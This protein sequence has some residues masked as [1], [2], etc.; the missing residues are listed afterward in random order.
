[1]IN[2]TNLY[3]DDCYYENE[4]VYDEEENYF[5]D[6]PELSNDELDYKS[7]NY[8]GKYVQNTIKSTKPIYP[9]NFKNLKNI[10]CL[11][12]LKNT[13]NKSFVKKIVENKKRTCEWVKKEINNKINIFLDSEYPIL[14]AGN[15]KIKIEECKKETESWF[16]VKEKKKKNVKLEEINIIIDNDKKDIITKCHFDNQCRNIKRLN[17]GIYIN[18]NID[19]K[20][21]YLHSYETIENYNNRMNTDNTNT[22]NIDVKEVLKN[23]NIVIPILKVFSKI[24]NP[25]SIETAKKTLLKEVEVEEEV[26]VIKE[27]QKIIFIKAPKSLETH[28]LN[29]SKSNGYNIKISLY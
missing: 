28:I 17:D 21:K 24:K 26:E 4:N 3:Y 5:D 2:Q 14:E 1:M 23:K 16:H 6:Y 20:C 15:T 10:T 27:E 8:K 25:W 7:E 13:V 9:A 22:D 29:M 19:K 11:K 12:S 18:K